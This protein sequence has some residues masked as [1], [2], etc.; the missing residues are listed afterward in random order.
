MAIQGVTFV[1]LATFPTAT[2]FSCGSFKFVANSSGQLDQVSLSVVGYVQ[3]L[4]F[5]IKAE[6]C[7]GA[8]DFTANKAGILR[9]TPPHAP[10]PATASPAPFDLSNFAAIA[11]KVAHVNNPSNHGKISTPPPTR[12]GHHDRSKHRKPQLPREL[13]SRWVSWRRDHKFVESLFGGWLADAD[14]QYRSITS[15][16]M[17]N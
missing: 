13:G 5:T 9:P 2:L 16:V 1:K 11:A 6:F 14:F 4:R 17:D 12:P 7:F 3:M 10:S 8:L 15:L